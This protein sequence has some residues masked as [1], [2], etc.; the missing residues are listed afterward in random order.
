MS[1]NAPSSGSSI[2]TCVITTFTN[3]RS[4]RHGS[5]PIVLPLRIERQVNPD[6]DLGM[7]FQDLDGFLVPGTGKHDR[8]R[9]GKAGVNEP[10]QRPVDAVT[11]PRVVSA[12]DQVNGIGSSRTGRRGGLPKHSGHRAGKQH[13]AVETKWS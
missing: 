8:H 13:A 5:P 7:S 12:D 9:E 11:E 2:P 4:A 1:S 10:L 6:G 3:G